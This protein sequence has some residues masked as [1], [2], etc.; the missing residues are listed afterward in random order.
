MQLT[1]AEEAAT[2]L[3]A[4]DVRDVARA[5]S[6]IVRHGNLPRVQEQLIH[7]A[8]IK[9]DRASY[10][11][12]RTLSEEDRLRVSELAS[13]QGTDVSTACRQLARCEQAGLVRREGDPRDLR[14]VLFSLTPEG[15][16]ALARLQTARLGQF[17][18][19]LSGWTQRDRH[20]LARLLTRFAADYFNHTGAQ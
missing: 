14:A 5:L 11:L 2:P 16:E 1:A 18:R 7:D 13:R 15:R 8:G 10:W 3:A 6:V 12:L 19:M 9:L 4:D 20:E 17:E